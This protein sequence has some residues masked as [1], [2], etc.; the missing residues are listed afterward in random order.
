MSK[1]LGAIILVFAFSSMASAT[2][3]FKSIESYAEVP[4]QLPAKLMLTFR[5]TCFEHIVDVVRKDIRDP[6]TNE[7][8]IYVGGIVD[9]KPVPCPSNAG[10]LVSVEAGGTYSGVQY[11]VEAIQ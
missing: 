6:I 3:R 1:I 2:A 7:V 9:G 8:T 11:P 10:K 4:G 5:L